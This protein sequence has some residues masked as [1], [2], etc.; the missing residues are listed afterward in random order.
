MTKCFKKCLSLLLAIVLCMGTTITA[1]AAEERDPYTIEG[2]YVEELVQLNEEELANLPLKQAETL[3]EEA[4]SVPAD[5]Y[6]ED[7]IRLGLDGLSFGLKFQ[8]IMDEIK[9][10]ADT[11]PSYPAK[12]RS[13]TGSVS[14]S[15]DIGVAWVR[16]TTSGHSPLTLG[17]I[18][19][20]TY[21]LEVDFITWDTAAAILASSASYD[22]FKDLVELVGTGAAGS[23]L[24][25]YICSVL[26]ITGAPATVASVA[27]G[28]AVGLGWNWL[29]SI[30]RSNMYDC[31]KGM[32]KNQYMKVQFMWSGNMVNKF[33]TTVSKGRS[34]SN[35]FPG[36]YGDWYKN[37]FG[38]LYS[39]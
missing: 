20:G 31:F 19:S 24:G 33:Y 13:T 3:F 7:E 32:S 34:I 25:A 12:T 5:N 27:V 10:T 8:L 39:Y 23:A 22:A 15:G 35:P 4:F 11:E 6:T 38:Y 30:D 9:K 36:T 29:K 28:A 14:Y 26:G 1:F 37:D 18:L 16:D 2:H 17:E 21:T